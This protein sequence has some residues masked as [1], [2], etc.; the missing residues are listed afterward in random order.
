[1]QQRFKN[2]NTEIGHRKRYNIEKTI[3]IF[4]RK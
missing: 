3:Q 2:N 1:M 4:N